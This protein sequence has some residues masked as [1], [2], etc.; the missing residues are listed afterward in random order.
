M[1]DSIAVVEN[2]AIKTSPALLSTIPSAVAYGVAT[3]VVATFN[4]N[5]SAVSA[6]YTGTWNSTTLKSFTAGTNTATFALNAIV[7][8]AGA[9]N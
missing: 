8:A 9:S 7:P 5:A 6:P 4:G 2:K 3:D 1:N